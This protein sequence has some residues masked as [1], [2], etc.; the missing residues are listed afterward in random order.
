MTLSRVAA[1]ALIASILPAAALAQ[2]P[3]LEPPPAAKLTSIAT[4]APAREPGKRMIVTG[5]LF[6]RNTSAPLPGRR[7]GVYQTDATGN[8]GKDRR[9]PRW[10]RLHG[11]LVTDSL[12]RYE[13]RT[14]RPGPYLG[15]G[16]PEHIHFVIETSHGFDGSIEL[17]FED[18]P[19]VPGRERESMRV[20][21]RFATVR[22]VFLGKDGVLRVERDLRSP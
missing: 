13:I 3:T 12:G 18:D 1:V 5:R 4:V 15:G 11:W 19:Q 9:N 8:Y 6:D 2:D 14:I 7:I 16:A 10:A 22:P 21:G 17:R 20:E